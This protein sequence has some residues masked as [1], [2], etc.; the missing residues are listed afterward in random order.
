MPAS[1]DDG[2]MIHPRWFVIGFAV[3]AVALILHYDLRLGLAAGSLVGVFA[4]VWLFLA[5]RFGLLGDDRPSDRR[6][7]LDR[8][9]KQLSNRREAERQRKDS[10][11]A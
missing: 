2:A 8:F 7:M 11:G 5:L 9:R 3:A 10:S 1:P 4:A 6:V